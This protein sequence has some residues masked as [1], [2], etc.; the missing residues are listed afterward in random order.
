MKCS[1][2]MRFILIFT[3]CQSTHFF[4]C[5]FSQY[6]N[7]S[8]YYIVKKNLRRVLIKKRT[9]RGMILKFWSWWDISV[10]GDD[11]SLKIV[12]H[13][14]IFFIYTLLWHVLCNLKERPEIYPKTVMPSMHWPIKQIVHVGDAVILTSAVSAFRFYGCSIITR[15]PICSQDMVNFLY[16]L[17]FLGP[18]MYGY[19]T[20][21][22]NRILT[23][24]CF[25]RPLLP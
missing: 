2:K 25:G 19:A 22:Y 16:D 24:W 10:T 3:V 17:G 18:W 23:T 14:N 1:I 11:T 8:L 5:R 4:T 12:P 21:S 6:T 13:Y 20:V 9:L 15:M 7:G